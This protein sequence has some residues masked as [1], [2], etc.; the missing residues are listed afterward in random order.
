MFTIVS[1]PLCYLCSFLGAVPFLPPCGP[2]PVSVAP[3]FLHVVTGHGA[4]LA[5]LS[6]PLHP[7]L[8]DPEVILVTVRA[9]SLCSSPGCVNASV[10]DFRFIL[11]PNGVV[12]MVIMCRFLF[13][14]GLQ[15][16]GRLL[17]L[18]FIFFQVTQQQSRHLGIHL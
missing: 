6:H 8:W 1:L 14:I 11:T 4:V 17:I 16:K 12:P 9:C 18:I 3:C 7:N 13:Q 5:T 15:W 2:A 10:V